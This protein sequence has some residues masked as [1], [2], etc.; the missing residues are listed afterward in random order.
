M[1]NLKKETSEIKN[2]EFT[3]FNSDEINSNFRES[4]YFTVPLQ[5]LKNIPLEHYAFKL[6]GGLLSLIYN[7]DY[8]IPIRTFVKI[9]FLPISS[10]K[11]KVKQ[12]KYNLDDNK[13]TISNVYYRYFSPLRKKKP[14]HDKQTIYGT[15][16]RN[17]RNAWK[18]YEQKFKEKPKIGD[19]I[20][21]HYNVPY[22][23]KNPHDHKIHKPYVVTYVY[24]CNITFPP[25]DLHSLRSYDKS[26]EY[27]NGIL[28]VDSCDKDVTEDAIQLSG[29][30]GNFYSDLP[31]RYGI[32]VPRKM[33]VE[34][35]N[36][37]KLVITDN[38]GDEYKFKSKSILRF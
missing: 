28:F 36:N 17:I 22:E 20:E 35:D 19:I 26:E 21:V 7:L 33:L 25:Y 6:S 15:D 8:Y 14:K 29:P 24:P 37:E 31:I 27:K 13:I 16:E 4:S 12:I 3:E 1:V 30:L 11:K 5:K 32:R 10:C 18:I 23:G 34:D 2:E 38:Y 9:L